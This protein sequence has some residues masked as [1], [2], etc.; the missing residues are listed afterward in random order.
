MKYTAKIEQFIVSYVG[1]IDM[2]MDSFRCLHT[3]QHWLIMSDDWLFTS[4][5]KS[6]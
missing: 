1:Y 3:I 4:E 6:I 2:D 5:N